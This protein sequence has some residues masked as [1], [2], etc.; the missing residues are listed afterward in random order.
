M[1]EKLVLFLICC[2][3]FLSESSI[4]QDT[5][6][7]KSIEDLF[8]LSLDDFLEVVITPSKLAQSVDDVTQKVDVIQSK[9][10]D[11]VVS[12]N[13]NICEIISKLPGVSV[14]VLSRNDANWGTYGGIGPK[15]ST[16]M[17]Q[18][19]PVDAFIEPMSID[20]TAID[21]IEVQ[22]GPASVM[23]PNY[24]SQDFAGNQSPL[25]GTVNMILKDKI[26]HSMTSFQTSVGSYNTLNSKFYHQNVS[27]NVH[28]YTGA[29]YEMS[30]YTNYGIDGSWLNM[31]KNPEYTK[32]KIYGGMTL[33]FGENEDQKLTIYSQGTFHNGDAGRVYKGFHNQYGI[34]NLGYYAKLSDRLSLQSHLGIR[35]YDRTWQESTYGVID[36]L[37]SDNGVKQLI[38]PVDISL[39]L[40]HGRSNALVLG[41]DYQSSRYSTWTEPVNENFMFGNISDAL[42]GGVYLQE[43]W[44]PVSGLTLRG[45][46]R[47]SYIRNTIALE[48]FGKPVSDELTWD[49]VLWSAGLRY[50]LHEKIS[51]YFNSGTSFST[52]TLK[53]I[54]GTIPMSDLGVPGRNGQ[55]PNPD[56]KPES[57]LGT[58]VGFDFILP[59]RIKMGIRGFY[60]ILKD[61][62]VDNVVS[63]NP[64]QTQSIN[65]ES[66]AGGGEAEISQKINS[67]VSWYVNATYM[68][69]G[70]HNE[71]N[72]DQH[73][74]DIPFSPQFV[75]NCGG[76]VQLPFGLTIIP[77]V[78]YNDGYYDGISK[79]GRTKY[80]PGLVLN[81]YLSQQFIMDGYA[82]ECF[83]RLYNLTN[84]DYHLPWQFKN[85]GLS[86][87]LGLK[88][89]FE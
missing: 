14:S 60:T 70:I 20:L 77:A 2:M 64:S 55:L 49:K 61:G 81:T 12:G 71:F 43:E 21:R 58:D 28:Y 72:S 42:Q 1:K 29:T 68:E 62:I 85:P 33:F 19:L 27:R 7:N 44:R 22:R 78:N 73:Q 47:Y 40:A 76:A 67:T 45:G 86:V 63:Q 80:I 8:T 74:S 54:G 16:Y 50:K 3:F 37:N 25:A 88:I 83:A 34:V 36:T 13:R 75:M 24:L 41:T 10:I 66:V 56:L 9:D 59:S 6:R 15:Y 52:P 48:N 38:V 82:I 51:I 30:D 84:N 18:G 26:D 65:T 69:T 53:S 23:Y 89:S 39:S 32:T 31:Q 46:F 17:V 11:Q 5:I 4:A 35:S 79:S 57:G 87:M